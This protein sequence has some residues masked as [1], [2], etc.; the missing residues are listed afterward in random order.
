[1]KISLIFSLNIVRLNIEGKNRYIQKLNKFMYKFYTVR[2]DFYTYEIFFFLILDIL[3]LN[4]NVFC[5]DMTHV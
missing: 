5:F 2:Y 4:C 3:A 1:M